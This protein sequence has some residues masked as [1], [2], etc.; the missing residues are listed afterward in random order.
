MIANLM[1]DKPLAMPVRGIL[2]GG[3]PTHW[4]GGAIPH[5]DDPGVGRVTSGSKPLLP[6][7]LL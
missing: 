1:E 3:K 6:S 7:L 5:A 4:G 2:W